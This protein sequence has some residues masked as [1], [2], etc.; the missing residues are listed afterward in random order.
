MHYDYSLADWDDLIYYLRD[1]PWEDIFKLGAPVAA[2][3][4]CDWVQ[5]GF[6]GY[7][8]DRKYQVKPHYLQCF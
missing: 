4:F 3:E 6:D 2:S 5:V 1:V 8:W 7:I